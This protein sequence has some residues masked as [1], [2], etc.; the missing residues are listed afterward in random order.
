MSYRLCLSRL[1]RRSF[2]RAHL[3]S[4][5]LLRRDVSNL[6]CKGDCVESLLRNPELSEEEARNELHWIHQ[7]V[8]DGF[9]S[10]TAPI[11]PNQDS[12]AIEGVTRQLC[13]RRGEGEPLQYLLGM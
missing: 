9:I 13:E 5:V 11:P 3:P 7:A 1:S 4:H 2:A 10:T 6:S 8:V 12:T